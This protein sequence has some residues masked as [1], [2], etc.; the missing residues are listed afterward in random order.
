[1]IYTSYM[2]KR[3]WQVL[4]SLFRRQVLLHS[5]ESNF[6]FKFS[7]MSGNEELTGLFS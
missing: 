4:L 7:A 2:T 1:M 6:S 3:M 5:S